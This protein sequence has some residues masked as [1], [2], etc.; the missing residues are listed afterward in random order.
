LKNLNVYAGIGTE[1]V[2][3]YDAFVNSPEAADYIQDE[4]FYMDPFT[5]L[6]LKFDPVPIRIG[7]RIDKYILFTLSNYFKG[8]DFTEFEMEG[9]YDTEFENLS[10]LTL[11]I[12]NIRAIRWFPFLSQ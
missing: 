12:Q 10:I 1:Q 11:K 8:K 7:N 4:D 3:I 5:E 9:I 6:R 2:K